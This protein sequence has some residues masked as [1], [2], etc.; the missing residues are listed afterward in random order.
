MQ[1]IVFLFETKWVLFFQSQARVFVLYIVLD[2]TVQHV[3]NEVL[4]T[5]KVT[6][7]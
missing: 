5:S 7:L 3:Y 6:S 4:G 1:T 2:I